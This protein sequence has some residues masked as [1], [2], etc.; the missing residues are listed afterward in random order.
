MIKKILVTVIIVLFSVFL[1]CIFVLY[2][3]PYD[4]VISRIDTNLRSNYSVD[5]SVSNVRYRFPFKLIFEDVRLVGEGIPTSI[6]MRVVTI[7]PRLIGKNV[8][9]T[10]Q[11]LRM[12]SEEFEV[13]GASFSI[14]SRLR[15]M[16]LRKEV[17]L[18]SV[19]SLDIRIDNARM[20]RVHL[21]GFEFS[22][23]TIATA[24]LS[25]KKRGEQLG[26]EQ[27][28]CKSDLFSSEISGFY[29]SREMDITVT[30]RLTDRFFERYAN[31][32]GLVESLTDNETIR[33]S[34]KGDTQRPTLKIESKPG[35]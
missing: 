30:L 31:L 6:S 3:F 33:F 28:F 32:T 34:I 20:E 4:S 2:N 35:I 11:G 25:L 5:L 19:E 17:S 8:V 15:L 1:L 10:G 12:N 29:G 16:K 7:R 9:V 26:I 22:S 18:A 23:F 24:L 14:A 21:S 13:K 27:G